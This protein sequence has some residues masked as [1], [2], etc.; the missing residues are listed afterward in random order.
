MTYV[1]NLRDLYRKTAEHVHS[2]G[3]CKYASSEYNDVQF[4]CFDALVFQIAMPREPYSSLSIKHL[5]GPDNVSTHLLLGHDLTFVENTEEA[6]SAAFEVVREFSRL[7]LPDKYLE[8][9]EAAERAKS[10]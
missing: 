1:S 7:R 9:W 8:V 10:R 3:R 4:T 5:I 6:F 2:F